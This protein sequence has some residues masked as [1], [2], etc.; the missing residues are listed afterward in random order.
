MPVIEI[1]LWEGRT[2]AQK[3]AMAKRITEAVVEEG[4]TE[5]EH[6]HIIFSDH[7]RS[8]W[9]IAGDLQDHH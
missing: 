9:A 4:K 8:N 7:D 1:K 3:A 5:A 6:V 2:R